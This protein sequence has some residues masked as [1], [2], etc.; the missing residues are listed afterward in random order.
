MKETLLSLLSQ[1][2]DLRAKVKSCSSPEQCYHLFSDK[3]KGLSFE[4]FTNSMKQ[5]YESFDNSES[6][7]LADSDVISINQANSTTAATITVTTITA[8]AG[9]AAV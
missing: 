1:D 6:G 9:S 5:I 8:A 3:V 2:S 4:S 7:L